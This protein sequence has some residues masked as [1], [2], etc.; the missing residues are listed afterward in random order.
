MSESKPEEIRSMVMADVKKADRKLMWCMVGFAVLE[1]VCAGTYIVMAIYEFPLSV[2][3]GVAAA[4][5]YTLIA[6]GLFGIYGHINLSMGRVIKA[7]ELIGEPDDER[8]DARP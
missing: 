2:L 7:I 8:P 5:V 1:A 4:C 3:I 6:A